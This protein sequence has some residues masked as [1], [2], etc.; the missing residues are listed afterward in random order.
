LADALRLKIYVSIWEIFRK[1]KVE[2]GEKMKDKRFGILEILLSLFA[3][4]GIPL[5]AHC[6]RKGRSQPNSQASLIDLL[7]RFTLGSLT[8]RIKTKRLLMAVA[9]LS[10]YLLVVSTALGE[11]TT[12]EWTDPYWSSQDAVE[13]IKTCEEVMIKLDSNHS[14]YSDIEKLVENYQKVP[15]KYSDKLRKKLSDIG[16]THW[17]QKPLFDRPN[18]A[19]EI[20]HNVIPK[21]ISEKCE[22]I[23]RKQR[24]RIHWEEQRIIKAEEMLDN[25]HFHLANKII[26]GLKSGSNKDKLI[27]I[28]KQKEDELVEKINIAIKDCRLTKPERG[29]RSA[30][31]LI[32]QLPTTSKERER[33]QKDLDKAIERE[34]GPRNRDKAGV[35]TLY[36]EGRDLWRESKNKYNAANYEDGLVLWRQSLEILNKA[37]SQSQC[38]QYKNKIKKV[39]DKMEQCE[40]CK[41]RIE[42][43]NTWRG[44]YKEFKEKRDKA[45]NENK[46]YREAERR[47]KIYQTSYETNCCNECLGGLN[48]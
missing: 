21:G 22:H 18:Y 37:H 8:V 5:S 36:M 16:L 39:I 1:F 17:E 14:G 35:K 19:L 24:Q 2:P 15:K 41:K 10:S 34:M 23:K 20:F 12:L 47:M 27:K 31:S 4:F 38:D 25:Y 30:E 48:K 43:C 32:N 7:T 45:A 13:Q 40:D 3:V 11:E 29:L 9:L 26:K 46:G 42:V 44:Y 28:F 33:L 6:G